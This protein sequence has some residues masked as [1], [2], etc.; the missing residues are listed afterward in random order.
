VRY[1]RLAFSKIE[2]TPALKQ[3]IIGSLEKGWNPDEISGRMKREKKEWYVSK[4]SIYRWLE[5]VRGERYK[6]YL[7]GY[8]QGRRVKKR[9]DTFGQIT[10]MTP[11]ELRMKGSNNR[12]RFGH[13]ESDLVVS[14]RGTEGGLSVHLERKSRY[15]RLQLKNR[16]LSSL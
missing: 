6:K 12:T 13:W 10:H 8:R 16:K 7:Y 5:T 15:Y 9:A 11:I 14:K 4:S 2:S 3:Y 1:R